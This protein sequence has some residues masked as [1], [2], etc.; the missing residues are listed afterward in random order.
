MAELL[1]LL[2]DAEFK[3]KIDFEWKMENFHLLKDKI[4]YVKDEEEKKM[5]A[6]LMGRYEE[7]VAPHHHE[8]RS[9]VVQNDMNEIN[10]LTDGKVVTGVIDFGHI[11][12]SNLI[13]EVAIGMYYAAYDQED[14]LHE[15]CLLLK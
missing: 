10:L 2:E 3:D 12:H 4:E 6:E 14:F 5:I 11:T 7:H 9:Q 15:G 13:S 1:A 8:L